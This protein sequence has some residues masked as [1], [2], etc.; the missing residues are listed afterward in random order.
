MNNK[1]I[2]LFAIV[3]LL[4]LSTASCKRSNS[5]IICDGDFCYW[6]LNNSNQFYRFDKRGGIIS[7]RARRDYNIY[8]DAYWDL[9]KKVWSV[10]ND[11]LRTHFFSG[12]IEFIR[13]TMIL[14]ENADTLYILQKVDKHSSTF[15]KLKAARKP[16]VHIDSFIE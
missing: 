6:H 3:S 7:Y 8:E 12:R 11:S 9:R 14:L 15:S 4:V 1:L 13:D 2:G 10:H 16:D 5:D